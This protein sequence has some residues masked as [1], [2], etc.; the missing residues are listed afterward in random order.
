MGEGNPTQ[1]LEVL[2]GVYEVISNQSSLFR[3][4]FMEV[5][6]IL[7][8]FTEIMLTVFSNLKH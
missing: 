7:L 5:I 8:I 4:E 3:S 2:E 1:K 6:V